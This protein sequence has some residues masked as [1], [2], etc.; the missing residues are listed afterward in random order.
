MTALIV[1][2]VVLLSQ[3]LAADASSPSSSEASMPAQPERMTL[4]VP[5]TT[6]AAPSPVVGVGVHGG[7]SGIATWYDAPTSGD[8]AAG[9]PLR[10]GNWRGRLVRVTAG[11]RSVIVRLT[12]WCACPHRLI[13]LDD[14]AFARLAPLSRG[15]V[16]V[17]VTGASITL[18][19]TD[20]P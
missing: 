2:L 18:P 20:A 14:K 6:W 5:S 8:A 4:V 10:V 9:P 15:V 3:S 17:V 13:D 11:G 19:A 12:D 1:S 16:R 7:L